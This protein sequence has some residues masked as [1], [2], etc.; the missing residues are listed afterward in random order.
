VSA[1]PYVGD[2]SLFAFNKSPKDWLPCDGT[3]LQISD[4]PVLAAVIGN[5]YGGDGTTTFAVPSL[6]AVGGVNYYIAAFGIY[7]PTP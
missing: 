7:P 3:V 4:Y 5:T 2:V 1:E 6:A